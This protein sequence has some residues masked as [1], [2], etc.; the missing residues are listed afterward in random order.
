MKIVINNVSN[1]VKFR[2]LKPGDVF[3]IKNDPEEAVFI[4]T[5]AYLE[6]GGGALDLSNGELSYIDLDADVI[7]HPDACMTLN[8]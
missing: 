6:D 1:I 2:T 7:P 8:V 5:S 4:R 3:M